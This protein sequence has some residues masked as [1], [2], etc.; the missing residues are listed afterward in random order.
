M[1]GSLEGII[2]HK[3]APWLI[4]NVQ[5]VGYE[6]EAPMTTF[7]DLPEI[8]QPVELHIH[9]VVRDDA[10]LLYG[11]S[12]SK[13]RT[14][15]RALIKV[16]G[17]GPRVALAILSTL[18]SNDF[19]LCLANE[20]VA[21]LT[22]VPGIGKKTA[23]RLIVEMKDKI[24]TLLNGDQIEALNVSDKADGNN[25]IQDAISG[26]VA[27]GYKQVEADKAIKASATE[28]LSSEQIIREALRKLAR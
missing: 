8:G 1:I 13:Q 25:R 24:K 28:G 3:Q 20:D 4:L 16:N 6:L 21:L 7:Y 11:F 5:G 19:V 17:I 23:E 9:M 12:R 14:L 15:F 26:L 10:H 2:K 18:S 22:K 27:L